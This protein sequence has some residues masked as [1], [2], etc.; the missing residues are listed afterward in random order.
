VHCRVSK[1]SSTGPGL[2]ESR[3]VYMERVVPYCPVWFTSIGF[4]RGVC[5]VPAEQTEQVPSAW[6]HKKVLAAT[7]SCLWCVESRCIVLT[8]F[9]ATN[10]RRSST[11]T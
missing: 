4:S 3:V 10:T 6:V 5:L 9:G 2:T 1:W 8:P 11:S 7:S